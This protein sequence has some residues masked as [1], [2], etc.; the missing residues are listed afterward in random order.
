MEHNQKKGAVLSGSSGSQQT[1]EGKKGE[2]VNRQP[3]WFCPAFDDVC[4][5][6]PVVRLSAAKDVLD[7]NRFGGFGRGPRA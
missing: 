4:V 3:L 1:L 2:S 6:W 7:K 5:F